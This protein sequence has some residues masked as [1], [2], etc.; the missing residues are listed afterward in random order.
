V[1][2]FVGTDILPTVWG[3][4]VNTIGYTGGQERVNLHFS[5]YIA[6]LRSIVGLRST[7][8]KEPIR[9]MWDS[10]CRSF[11]RQICAELTH[12]PKRMG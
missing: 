2:L 10:T 6:L 11:E 1:L 8:G 7:V 4:A 5:S 3:K 9:I 12:L